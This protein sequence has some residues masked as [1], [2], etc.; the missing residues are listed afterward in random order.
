MSRLDPHRYFPADPAQRR[1]AAELFAHIEKLPI[2]SPH[3]HTDPAW[4]ADDAPFE[5]AVSLLL[6]PDHY[7]LRLLYSQ[8][9][10]LE[11][12]GLAPLD[13]DAGPVETDRRRIWRRFASHYHVF[14]GTPC[15]AW[16]DH[17]FL[18][19]FGL[20]RAF[21]PETADHYY[22]AI[23][24]RLATPAFRPR[25]LFER[26]NIEVIATTETSL[27]PLKHHEAIAASGWK[28]RVLTTLRPDEITDPDHE[29]FRQALAALAGIT[30]EDTTTWKGYLRAIENRRAFFRAHGATATD[31]GHLTAQTADLSPAEAEALFAKVVGG[32]ADAGAREL[33]RAQMLTEM[34]R[35]S[36]EDGMVMQ[37]HPGCW[38]NHNAE[39]YR[40]HGRN[41]GG[42]MPMVGAFTGQLKPLLD[43]FGNRADFTLILFT[44]D[45]TT[46]SRELAPLAGH[47]PCLRLG[48]AWWFHDSPE[49]MMRYRRQTTESAGF[50]NTAGFN[51]DTR[52]FFS[53]PARHDLARRIDCAYL[54]ELVAQ[55]RLPMEE[56][57]QV[58]A[59]LTYNLPKKVYRL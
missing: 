38:R 3:G 32:K 12:I 42:D 58:A 9:V 43:R 29:Q 30:G 5:D 45:E 14:R 33:F 18:E 17:T 26:F 4:F 8:G 31:H 23:N 50:Y 10:S 21:G 44:L 27:D 20:D 41:V 25:A 34:A 54:A 22:D 35:M 48:P 49:G 13:G 39:L 28:G 19:V 36:V 53:I 15:R 11:S 24:E 46:Y 37:I 55:G 2:V 1:I 59:D 16:L 52:A 47:Y 56:A 40:R 6:W 7:L 51:D 57:A